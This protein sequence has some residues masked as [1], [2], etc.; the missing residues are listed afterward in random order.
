[1]TTVLAGEAWLERH[2]LIETKFSESEMRESELGKSRTTLRCQ[3]WCL[4]CYP[5][6]SVNPSLRVSKM[7]L[8]I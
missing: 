2:I 7:G 5:R 6:G 8:F 1:M 4:G 3:I